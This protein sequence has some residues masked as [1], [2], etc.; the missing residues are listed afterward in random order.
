[1]RPWVWQVLNNAVLT[2]VIFLPSG[3]PQRRVFM[4]AGVASNFAIQV[5]GQ[6]LLG[7]LRSPRGPANVLAFLL[8]PSGALL[9]YGAGG[10]DS[11]FLYLLFAA[12][13]GTVTF[14]DESMNILDEELTKP[15]AIAV[16][17]ALA[18]GG[19]V[20]G[21]AAFAHQ[22]DPSHRQK[23]FLSALLI[24]AVAMG[25]DAVQRANARRRRGYADEVAR[26]SSL[27]ESI[28]R[29]FALLGEGNL[30]D[31]ARLELGQDLGELKDIYGGLSENFN[32]T[33]E[34][35]RSLVSR[36]QEGA[37]SVVQSGEQLLSV[38]RDAASNAAQQSS[39]VVTTSATV[40]QLA[41]TAAQ[42]AQTANV[43][44]ELAGQTAAR[45]REG[46]EAVT[47]TVATIEDIAQHVLGI[48]ERTSRLGRLT[49]SMG[50]ILTLIDDIAEQTNLLAL[51]AAIEAARAGEA[52]RGFSVV[53][54]EVRKLAER[55]QDATR[56]IQAI[57]GQIE[58]EA[59]STIAATDQGAHEVGEG[60]TN[61]GVA[62]SALDGI[63]EIAARTSKA[64]REISTATATQ[65]AASSQVVAA[66]GEVAKAAR[67]QEGEAQDAAR[68]ADALAGIATGLLE[69]SGR[70]TL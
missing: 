50:S 12:A 9:A 67:Q 70:F 14:L 46:E 28:S 5:G 62:A 3:I 59:R 39:A 8:W 4:I 21:V 26:I 37:A 13:Y 17:H 65:G 56:D 41:Q 2:G 25:Y 57:I 58:V 48:A 40:E 20:F 64:A 35:L 66:V 63:T 23:L 61:A 1:M 38:A 49:E 27:N 31:S 53:A 29:S 60:T 69:L 68:E 10:L 16:L 22:L 7:R 54:D 47:D 18:G 43:V 51:N 44:A 33:V 42:I 34:A 36:I 30:S 6:F 15:R 52:G 32:L 11:P 24:P 55:S 45:A 19:A